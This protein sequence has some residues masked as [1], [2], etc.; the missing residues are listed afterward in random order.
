MLDDV[1][2][3]NILTTTL[4]QLSAAQRTHNMV[5]EG[6]REMV[7][8]SSEISLPA[9][10]IHTVIEAQQQQGQRFI[11]NVNTN[12]HTSVASSNLHNIGRTHCSTLLYHGVQKRCI[13]SDAA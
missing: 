2:I 1:V 8:S 12:I 11:G 10:H 5:E 3:R 6:I 7:P 13:I 4:T 9:A